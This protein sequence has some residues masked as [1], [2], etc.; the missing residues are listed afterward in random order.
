[1][2]KIVQEA[3]ERFEYAS[4]EESEQRKQMLEDIRFRAL[5]QWPDSVKTARENDP[6]G[7]RPCLTLDRTNQYIRQVVNDARQNKPSIKTWP[8]DS[9]S[10][11][12]VAEIYNGIIRHIE[13]N[14]N[15]EV[16]YDTALDSA[17]TGGLGYFRVLTKEV[18]NGLQDIFISPIRNPLA[19]YFDPDSIEVDGSD[20]MW[21]LIVDDVPAKRFKAAYPKAAEI[22]FSDDQNNWID[23]DVVKVAEYFKVEEKER[24]II[25]LTDGSKHTEVEYW[26]LARAVG[27][28]PQVASNEMEKYREVKWYKL[29]GKEVL[30][31]TVFPASYIPVIPVHGNEYWIENK[32]ILT[33]MIRGAKDA[34]RLYNYSYSSMIER[35]ALEPKAPYIAA[36]GQVE[37]FAEMWKTAN[38]TN[39]AVLVYDPIDNNGTAVPPPQ[40]QQMDGSFSSWIPILQTCDT[41]IQASLGMYQASLGM[42]SN[43]TSGKAIMARQREGDNATFHYID[44]LSRSMRH[45]GKIVV[46]MIPKTYDTTRVA[47][48]IGEDESDQMVKIDP[49]QGEAVREVKKPNGKIEKIYNLGIGE[50]DV[51]VS[52][53]PSY[54]TKRQEAADGMIQLAQ[55]NPELFGM[56][57]DVIVKN[58]DWPGADEIA[59]RL[60]KMLPPNLQDAPEGTPELPEEA[61]MIVDQMSQGLQQAQQGLQEAGMTIQEMEAKIAELEAEKKD[62]EAQ[63]DISAYDAETR[64]IAAL[65]KVMSSEEIQQIVLSTI[66]NLMTSPDISEGE[67]EEVGEVEESMEPAFGSLQ[68]EDLPPEDMQFIQ[69]TILANQD[70]PSV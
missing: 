42:Q 68:D 40:R 64:R 65:A 3:M 8:V 34:Q 15:A 53:G 28:K 37:Q 4:T 19:V 26:E 18:R 60:K 44:N 13:N 12:E 29:N 1:M 10:D 31:E 45:L 67:V 62:K 55:A 39:R 2:D 27:F 54:T 20:A 25:T 32:R 38:T 5:E 52:V 50:Y 63:N 61:Q 36:A 51:T 17:C 56:I 30:E 41:N 14:S 43:E 7:A 70:Q 57:G 33:G 23:K 47:R 66:A 24:N 58:L 22:D 48:I 9:G 11:V 69:E 59:K 46:E 16:A 49:S 35:V 21:C 6:N